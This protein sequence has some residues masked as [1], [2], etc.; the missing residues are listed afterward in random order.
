M[1][2][3]SIIYDALRKLESFD[4]VE[5]DL[6]SITIRKIED[7]IQ[8]IKP[9]TIPKENLQELNNQIY[10]VIV[11][12]YNAAGNYSTSIKTFNVNFIPP[13]IN[14]IIFSW[15]DYLNKS[16]NSGF[17]TIETSNI[18]NLHLVLKT[19]RLSD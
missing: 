17:I 6:I 1:D 13:I 19:S 7:Y 3:N 11:D 14:N 4:N 15:G 16:I 8:E 18:E 12:V 5:D 2:C 9:S 10:T